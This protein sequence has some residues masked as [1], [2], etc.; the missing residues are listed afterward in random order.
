MLN[1][2]TVLVKY[3]LKVSTEHFLTLSLSFFIWDILL[4]S[5]LLKNFLLFLLMLLI[6]EIQGLIIVSWVVHSETLK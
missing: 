5:S 1:N 6:I 3:K 2:D 4:I